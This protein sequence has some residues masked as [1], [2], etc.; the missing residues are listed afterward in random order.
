ML[1]DLKYITPLGN[2]PARVSAHL[3]DTPAHVSAYLGDTPAHISTSLRD[4]LGRHL[5]ACCKTPERP[6][7]ALFNSC[8]ARLLCSSE[9]LLRLGHVL[10][11]TQCCIS[12]GLKRTESGK[13]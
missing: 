3:G 6:P 4:T 10:V 1:K 11:G 12:G 13:T 9:S 7:C 5:W 8:W 2:T